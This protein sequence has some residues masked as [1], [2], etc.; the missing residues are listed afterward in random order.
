MVYEM[1]VALAA[2]PQATAALTIGSP[3]PALAVESWVRG[4]PLAKF[5]PGRV[6]IVEF[7]ATCGPCAKAMSGLVQLQEKYR[8]RA[9]EVV[10]VAAA[11]RGPT[12]DAAKARLDKWLNAKVPNLNYRIALNDSGEMNKLWLKP[13]TSPTIPVSFVIDRDGRIAM[14]DHP[15]RLDDL[16]P[17][18]LE[19][20][21]RD[22]NE[23]ELEERR[24]ITQN[25]QVA[26]RFAM[27]DELTSAMKAE[28]WAGALSIIEQALRAMPDDITFR[29]QQVDVLLHKMHDIQGISVMRKLVRDAIDRN[30]ELWMACAIRELFDPSKD[31]S[32]FPSAERLAIGKDLS[33]R[34]LKL[35]PP[36][37]SGLKINSY[38]AVAQYYYAIG[39]KERAIELVEL[40]LRSLGIEVDWKEHAASRLVQ[41][42]ANYK[43]ERVCY[44]RF[45]ASPE[46]AVTEADRRGSSTDGAP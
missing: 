17:K 6:Y 32:D 4:R 44:G 23:A 41:A 2:L 24:R 45:C 27:Q 10:G 1:I 9:V 37:G 43:S 46:Q 16:L 3:A 22:S 25:E 36:A 18:I 34:V 39:N 28:N 19:G 42:L 5:E 29:T 11:E 21:W 31:N 30:S 8:D 20:T 26:R 40:S 38:E 14:I 12:A 7:F 13:S 33:E 15:S 35:N